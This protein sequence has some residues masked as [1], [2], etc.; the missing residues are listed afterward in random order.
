MSNTPQSTRHAERSDARADSRFYTT[1]SE[2]K[3]KLE[4]LLPLKFTWKGRKHKTLMHKCPP[5]A[6]GRFIKDFG[7]F[8]P[9]I[10]LTELT[11]EEA[12]KL[13]EQGF[14]TKHQCTQNRKCKQSCDDRLQNSL[15]HSLRRL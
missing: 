9:D 5:P 12:E 10:G 7:D 2:R 11:K 4:D 14:S 3:P 1:D 13:L 6:G 15:F 8:F